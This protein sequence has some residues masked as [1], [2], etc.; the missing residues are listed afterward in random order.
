MQSTIDA[1][2][3]AQW[4]KLIQDVA[5]LFDDL[6]LKRG[7][8]YYK[9][10]RVRPFTLTESRKIITLVEGME[11]YSVVIELDNL[12]KSRCECPV[13]GPCK[14][15][16]AVL[17]NYAEMEKRPVQAVANAKAVSALQR[18]SN[19]KLPPGAASLLER[20]DLLQQQAA[21][22]AEAGIAEWRE[23]CISCTAPLAHSIRTPGYA[24]KAIAAILKYKPKLPVATEKLFQLHTHLFVLEMLTKPQ[25]AAQGT[26]VSSMGYFAHLTLTELQ[27]SI[28][29][30]L[31]SGLPLVDE[32]EQWTRT[33]EMLGYLRQQ[34]LSEPRGRSREHPHFS[35]AYELFWN[36]WLRP[37]LSDNRLYK[38]ELEH[39]HA[40]EKE[41]GSS[42][43][44]HSWLLAQSRMYFYLREDASAW[45]LLRTAA[46]LPALQPEELLGF[47]E[48]LFAAGEWKRLVSWLVETGPLL[49]SRIYGNLKDYSVY[50]DTAV[51]QL[52][53]SEPLMWST[54]SGMLPLSGEIYGE[55]LL[56]HGRWQA[57]MDYQLTNGK[58]PSDFRVRDL[59][60]LEKNAPET[61][62]P[63]YHQA[64]ERYVLEKN[65]Q[66]YKAAVK[67]LKRLAKLYKKMKQDERW[68]QYIEAY[69]VRHSRLRALQEELRKGKLIT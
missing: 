22:M 12:G 66:S 28:E 25:G 5:Y 29:Q 49:G 7:F 32:P 58:E 18:Q 1:M 63:F 51:A 15:M 20:Q 24:E 56:A 48:P 8:Q 40:A 59:Q 46:D 21:R 33:V 10:K 16:A 69:S 14:H 50:W 3:D 45:T 38:E 30:I 65:R 53:E 19:A 34:M 35:T 13:K 52:P 2:D 43:S 57:W 37:N 47:L 60:P 62:L 17:M 31:V 42:L 67:L 64:A 11:D 27:Q 23:F 26:F 39:L 4:D 9:Q 36:H 44:R 68:E 41:M 55:K 6:T 54:L 61:L